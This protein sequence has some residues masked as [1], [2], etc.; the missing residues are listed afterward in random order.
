MENIEDIKGV[1]AYTPV[2][3]VVCNGFGTLAYGRK[4]CP[5][6]EGKAYILIPNKI[7]GVGN[8]ESTA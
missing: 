7:E 2:K 6:C 4:V 1:P 3:C 5:A 8:G